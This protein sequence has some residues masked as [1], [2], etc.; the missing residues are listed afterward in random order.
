ML[1]DYQPEIEAGKLVVY[2]I[3]E[4]HLVRID[5]CGEVWGRVKERAEIPISNLRDRQTYYGALN[6]FEPEFLMEQYSA[7]N[8]ENTVDFVSKLQNKTPEQRLLLF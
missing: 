4:C 3:N 5:L 6:L 2:T 7:G 8:G 1:A